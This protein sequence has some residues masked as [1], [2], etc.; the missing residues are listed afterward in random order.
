MPLTTYTA[1]EVLTAASLNANLSFA[2]TNPPSGLTLVKAQV[3][4]SAVS[5][6]AVTDAFSTTYDNY[7]IVYSGGVASTGVDLGL[8]LGATATNYYFGFGYIP[9][10]GALAGV[11]IN[12]GA[13]WLYAGGGNATLAF[14]NCDIY[15]PFLS[16]QSLITGNGA[17]ASNIGFIGGYLNNTTSYTAFTIT[18][19]SGTLTGGTIFVYGYLKA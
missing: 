16:D 11:S 5:S 6:V 2:A 14:L 3:V 17:N 9:Y 7:R 15:N 8:T 12:N 4:G 19:S 1:G 10:G 13:G 18:P